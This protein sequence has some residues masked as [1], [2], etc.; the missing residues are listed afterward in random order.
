[1]FVWGGGGAFQ[2]VYIEA[3]HTDGRKWT[4]CLNLE[5]PDSESQTHL[6]ACNPKLKALA[7]KPWTLDGNF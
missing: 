5:H 6:A 4:S 7:A 3:Y 2:Q 1:M